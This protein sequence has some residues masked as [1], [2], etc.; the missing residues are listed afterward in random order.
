MCRW[1]GTIEV[2]LLEDS[3][4]DNTLIKL[5]WVGYI[6]FSKLKR[7]VL[8][9]IELAKDKQRLDGMYDF[10]Y[11]IKNWENIPGWTNT[12]LKQSIFHN[13]KIKYF[14]ENI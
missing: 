14:T 3:L 1:R 9:E 12:N 2:A 7:Y 6:E 10:D 4:S 13:I 8:H 11:I 5:P